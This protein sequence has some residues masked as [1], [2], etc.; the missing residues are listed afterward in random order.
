MKVK[1]T[2]K[3]RILIANLYPNEAD[4]VTQILVRDISKKVDF[5][6]EEIKNIEL[7]LAGVGRYVWNSDAPDLEVNFTE[8]ELTLLRNQIG[9]LDRQKKITQ[10][11]LDLVLK[12]KG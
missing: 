3:D 8:K 12:L 6:Q 5:S 1:L 4:L 9:K 7:K 11:M 2:V 10:N